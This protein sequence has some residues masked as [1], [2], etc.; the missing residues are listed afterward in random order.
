VV[1]V[2]ADGV[3]V[4]DDQ[5]EAGAVAGGGPLEHLEVAV[6]VA[7]G[8]DGTLAD[9]ALDADGLAGFVVHEVRL[10]QPHKGW[11]AVDLLELHFDAGA[12]DLRGG[13]AVDAIGPR[14]HKVDAAAR[15][16]EG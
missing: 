8:E 7:E 5:A 6:G 15:D 10:R 12:Y 1:G 2:F 9:E 13:N 11:L 14:T 3:G 16:D 4:V